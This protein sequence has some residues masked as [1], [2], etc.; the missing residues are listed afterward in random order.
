VTA[1]GRRSLPE[2][3]RVFFG[4]DIAGGWV[5]VVAVGVALLWANN[6]WGSSDASVWRHTVD[7]GG[8]TV[9][10]FTTVQSWVNGGLMAVFFLVVGLEIGR[11]R[12]TGEL[13]TLAKA[14]VPVVGALGGM[15]GAGVRG[16]R[17][18]VGVGS[19]ASRPVAAEPGT[20]GDGGGGRRVHPVV[21][22]GGAARMLRWQSAHCRRPVVRS[23]GGQGDRRP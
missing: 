15:A 23:A 8:S 3:F 1:S 6:P 4:S 17:R 20:A 5:L 13:G 10:D 19:V 11:E 12:R 18:A 7:I 14:V 16:G 2:S 21:S 22:S 9:A